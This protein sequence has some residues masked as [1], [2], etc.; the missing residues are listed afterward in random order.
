VLQN[1]TSRNQV[2]IYVGVWPSLQHAV[3]EGLGKAIPVQVWTVPEGFGRLRAPEFI[4]NR[5][6][7]WQVCH[8]YAPAAFTPQETSPVLI[9]ERD[10]VDPR[11]SHT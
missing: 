2:A 7:K 6:M 4:H 10:E 8:P 5:H 3:N 9:S 11:A 1:L